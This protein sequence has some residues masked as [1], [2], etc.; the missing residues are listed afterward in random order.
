[1]NAKQAFLASVKALI[2]SLYEKEDLGMKTFDECYI[3]VSCFLDASIT[4]ESFRTKDI[5]SLFRDG[6]PKRTVELADE[7]FLTFWG[8]EDDVPEDADQIETCIHLIHEMFDS[9]GE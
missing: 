9:T 3:W 8:D 1:M 6:L 7:F 4:T 5:A 2:K